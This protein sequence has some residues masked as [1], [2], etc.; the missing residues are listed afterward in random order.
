MEDPTALRHHHAGSGAVSLVLQ[1]FQ[2]YDRCRRSQ[3]YP[4]L[5]FVKSQ[6]LTMLLCF[7]ARLHALFLTR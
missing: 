5:A 3:Q 2:T 6:T 4:S 7:A 1:K